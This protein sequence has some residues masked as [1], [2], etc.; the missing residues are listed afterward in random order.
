MENTNNT[1][2]TN[3]INKEIT[4][5]PKDSNVISEDNTSSTKKSNLSTIK[6]IGLVAGGVLLGALSTSVVLNNRKEGDIPNITLTPTDEVSED[7]IKDLVFNT[8]PKEILQFRD[9][10][11]P[12]T[13]KEEKIANKEEWSCAYLLSNGNSLYASEDEKKL[14]E[15]N[16]DANI[17]NTFEIREGKRYDFSYINHIY[18]TKDNGLL[19]Q[20]SLEDKGGNEALF[21]AKYSKDGKLITSAQKSY[22]SKIIYNKSID[23]LVIFSL[24]D[25]ENPNKFSVSR[26]DSDLKELTSNNIEI[27]GYI[28]ERNITI[29]KDN[30]YID[31]Y[32]TE[33][34]KGN[35]YKSIS[36]NNEGKIKSMPLSNSDKGVTHSIYKAEDTIFKTYSIVEGGRSQDYLSISDSSHGADLG[37]DVYS[38]I[39]YANVVS[40][41]YIVVLNE[42]HE[43]ERV[44]DEV[45]TSTLYK[46]IKYD[47]N[48]NELWNKSFGEITNDN[49]GLDMYGLQ[50]DIEEDNLIIRTLTVN[51]DS[52]EFVKIKVHI[53][54]DKNGNVK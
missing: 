19:L 39:E 48:F 47:N 30:I 50:F 32:T 17:V 20:Y 21:V 4:N 22:D 44:N 31:V 13:K 51:S 10:S 23:E 12:V 25:D 5:E 6:A 16:E 54:I 52:N 9:F 53:D 41:G 24:I 33:E 15:V 26:Y 11:T 42:L 29:D 8:H 27:K 1:N 28:D 7:E 37:L 45:Y 2:N 36:V 35:T 43:S 14:Y 46:V 3:N 34:N 49:S 18:E 40:D 38:T